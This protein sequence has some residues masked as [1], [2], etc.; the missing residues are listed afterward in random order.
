MLKN[1]VTDDFSRLCE[2]SDKYQYLTIL[3][4][5]EGGPLSST[6]YLNLLTKPEDVLALLVVPRRMS[7]DTYRILGQIHN[8]NVGHLGVERT[9]AKL[10]RSNNIW[11]GMR[12]DVIAFIRGCPLC[13]KCPKLK[14]QYTQTHVR[15]QRMGS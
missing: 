2:V 12:S 13:Q 15:P 4:E 10:R 1:V 3:D 9:I 5:M 8:S 7:Q 14:Y 11:E 6:E